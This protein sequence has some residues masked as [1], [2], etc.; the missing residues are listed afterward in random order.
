MTL[1][2]NPWVK[3]VSSFFLVMSSRATDFL[4][5]PFRSFMDS[6]TLGSQL[7]YFA[8]KILFLAKWRF[9]FYVHEHLK[10]I[11]KIFFPFFLEIRL[12]QVTST[13]APFPQA[14]KNSTFLC[15]RGKQLPGQ[16]L[17]GDKR[18]EVLLSF[19][20]ERCLMQALYLVPPLFCIL[21]LINPLC[22]VYH[23]LQN[24]DDL[25]LAPF[26]FSQY[27]SGL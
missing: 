8:S 13:W 16:G 12:T 24:Y 21:F 14:S 2:N 17:V 27:E 10:G 4:H 5:R 7:L 1:T 20:G 25:F 15:W 11:V 9:F 22:P 6:D 23:K 18:R 3:K 26:H 19:C